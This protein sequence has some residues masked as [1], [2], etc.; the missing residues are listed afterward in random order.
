MRFGETYPGFE[1]ADDALASND[2]VRFN[3]FEANW[4]VLDF[5]FQGLLDSFDFNDTLLFFVEVLNR[6]LK[7]NLDSLVAF[8]G[9]LR[10]KHQ[11]K[12]V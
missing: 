12:L 11:I 2:G 5:D 3:L 4:K 1:F 9:V 8:I 6:V 7:L 10:T